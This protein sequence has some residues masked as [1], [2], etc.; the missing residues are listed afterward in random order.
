MSVPQTGGQR[1]AAFQIVVA[2]FLA[3]IV[4][5]VLSTVVL[6]PVH[7]AFT[8]AAFWSAETV[9]GSRLLTYVA[10][11]WQFFPAIILFAILAY[12]WVSTRQ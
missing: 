5:A 2:A 3:L 10:G 8:N 6:F 9:V 1:S 11:I 12:V 7:N 4:G